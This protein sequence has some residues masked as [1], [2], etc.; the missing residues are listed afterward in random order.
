MQARPRNAERLLKACGS[1]AEEAVVMQEL[2]GQGAFSCW[3]ALRDARLDL[4][5][6]VPA[7][8]GD[9][10]EWAKRQFA[11]FFHVSVS[12]KSIDIILRSTSIAQTPF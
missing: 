1:R 8:F 6:D 9:C 7:G 10:L 2:R 4:E 12:C 3:Q 11:S 5:A